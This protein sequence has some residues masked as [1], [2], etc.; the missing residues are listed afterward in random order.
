[1]QINAS[2]RALDSWISTV[3][4]RGGSL[5]FTSVHAEMRFDTLRFTSIMSVIFRAIKCGETLRKEAKSALMSE[6]L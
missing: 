2:L 6:Q 1:M 5:S 4:I 3:Y